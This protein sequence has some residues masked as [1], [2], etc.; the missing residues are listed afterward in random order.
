MQVDLAYIRA[1]KHIYVKIKNIAF[2]S[3]DFKNQKANSDTDDVKHGFDL[4]LFVA[5]TIVE[6]S[7]GTFSAVPSR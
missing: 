6:E 3:T 7:N 5:Q 1:W 4:A 2:E